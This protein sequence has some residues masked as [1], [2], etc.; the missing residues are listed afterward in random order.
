[1]MQT[2]DTVSRFFS[3]SPKRQLAIER[4]IA[5]L[6]P[7][8][9]RRKMKEM[10]RTR[11]VERHEAFE[12]FLDL[13]MATLSC[14][15]EMALGRP[16]EWN[17]ETRSD[18]H[19]LFLAVSQFSFVVALVLTQKVLGYTKGLSIKLQGR[20]VDMARAHKDIKSVKNI[21][22]QK[23]SEVDSFHAEIMRITC[24]VMLMM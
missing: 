7:E 15:E 8:E 4:W 18:A 19:S 17:R 11:W 24:P 12:V 5:E 23:R 14:L 2:A 21:V 3:N 16:A 22:K 6:F 1:M 20:Y 9:K 13:F 10:C